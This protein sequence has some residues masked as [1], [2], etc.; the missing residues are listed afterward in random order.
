MN[1]LLLSRFCVA[2]ASGAPYLFFLLAELLAERGHKVWVI[3]KKWKNVN[4]SNHK[5]IKTIFIPP[6]K[7]FQPGQRANI[8]NSICYSLSAIKVGYSLIKKEKISIIHSEPYMPSVTGSILSLLTSRPH[9][10]TIHSIT[11]TNKE[12]VK[13]SIKQ[14]NSKW[15]IF[16]KSIFI[17]IFTKTNCSVL[18]PVMVVYGVTFRDLTDFSL[19]II[20]GADLAPAPD[21]IQTK[22]PV[23]IMPELD[24]ILVEWIPYDDLINF[25]GFDDSQK[26]TIGILKFLVPDDT[27]NIQQKLMQDRTPFYKYKPDMYEIRDEQFM[28]SQVQLDMFGVPTLTSYDNETVEADDLKRIITILQNNNIKVVLFSIPYSRA[29]LDSLDD[30]TFEIFTTVLDDISDEF[31][32]PVYHLYD[33]Y[34]DMNIWNDHVHVSLNK[35]ATIYTSDLAK[36][37]S[38]EI[39]P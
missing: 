4:G 2:G 38:S 24:K 34:A 22:K 28:S 12:F 14:G 3:T 21:V 6:S 33:K 35:N 31:D 30:S 27:Q 37:V 23:N 36:I 18:H 17:K 1:L 19:L 15:Q 16:L 32:V 9:I 20:D 11:S 29:L 25:L 26:N 5:N 8:K 7:H 39:K 10:R 13:E